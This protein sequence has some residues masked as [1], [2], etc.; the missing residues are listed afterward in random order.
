MQDQQ[1]LANEYAQKI[2]DLH[3][4]Y[5]AKLKALY[6][7]FKASTKDLTRPGADSLPTTEQ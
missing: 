2:K 4:E 5:E 3:K 7:E 6:L 1:K